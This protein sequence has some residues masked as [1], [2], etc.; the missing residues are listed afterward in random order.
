MEYLRFDPSLA[1]RI[2]RA[3]PR[4]PPPALT[5]PL[6]PSAAAAAFDLA[7]SKWFSEVERDGTRAAEHAE[8]MAEF[9]KTAAAQDQDFFPGEP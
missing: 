1:Q 2:E 7:R 3:V 9:L 4:T 5:N 6:F 8:E